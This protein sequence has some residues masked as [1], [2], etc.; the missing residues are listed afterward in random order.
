MALDQLLDNHEPISVKG[1]PE[2]AGFADPNGAAYTALLKDLQCN[3]LTPHGF[4]QVH[5][6]FLRFKDDAGEGYVETKY[7]LGML[8]RDGFGRLMV[9][10]A[11]TD[12]SV[13]DTMS[14][15]L[16]HLAKSWAE[17]V[18][19]EISGDLHA[20]LKPLR[21]VS[22]HEVYVVRRLHGD[23]PEPPSRWTPEGP[24]PVNVLLTRTGHQKLGLKLPP[25]AAFQDGMAKR[26]PQLNDPA[27]SKWEEH[28]W[29]AAKKEPAEIDA[30][31][32]VAR[33]PSA[34][35]ADG[36]VADS[37]VK[38][39]EAIVEEHATIVQRELGV[40]LKGIGRDGKPHNIEPFGFRDGLS[41]PAFYD[42]DRAYQEREKLSGQAWDAFAPLRLVLRPD[43]NGRTPQACGSYFVYRKLEQNIAGFHEQSKFLRDQPG[44]TSLTEADVRARFMGRTPQGDP[45]L[46]ASAA[47]QAGDSRPSNDF[48]FKDDLTGQVCPFFAH[49]RKMNP[50]A[51]MRQDWGPREHRIARRAIP[52]GPAIERNPDGTPVDGRVKYL[53][54]GQTGSIGLLFLCAQ[55]DIEQQFEFLQSRWANKADHPRG[56][57]WGLDALIGQSGTNQVALNPSEPNHRSAV[58]PVVTLKGGEYFFAPSIGCLRGLLD[59]LLVGSP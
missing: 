33:P 50:R 22:E 6:Y 30:L 18:P 1:G 9:R 35:S 36:A 5:Y 39:F 21:L 49:V 15:A 7:L 42:S 55:G 41:Q 51:G 17:G 27:P 2:K 20:K 54:K 53:E 58:A 26:G 48:D 32:M 38:T 45:L 52:Y 24:F 28:Y 23:V 40:A 34:G 10:N 46:P 43:P 44:L 3:I 8:A 56:G 12:P 4:G 29:D 59:D 13:L 19:G 16:I 11:L 37:I 47:G 31:V 25:S 57:I 14:P